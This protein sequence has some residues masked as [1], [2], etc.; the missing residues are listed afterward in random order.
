MNRA[1]QERGIGLIIPHPGITSAASNPFPSALIRV[2]QVPILASP[3]F[4]EWFSSTVNKWNLT[5]IN[6]QKKRPLNL[7]LILKIINF[8]RMRKKILTLIWVGMFV[9]A[10][11]AQTSFN[12][13][14]GLSLYGNEG[15]PG[16]MY[17]P[18]WNIAKL[19]DNT[20]L[21]IGTHFGINFEVYSESS[22]SIFVLDLPIMMELNFG[23]GSH[24]KNEKNSGQ[25][26]GLGYGFSEID[27]FGSSEGIV[28]NAG[29]RQKLK[30]ESVGLR[31]SYLY[32]LK[33]NGGNVVSFGLFYTFKQNLLSEI[34]E[35]EEG[36]K[37]PIR[38][39][40]ILETIIGF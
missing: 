10:T 33:S 27:E 1:T 34:K 2:L 36:P 9:F 13:A 21:S 38:K 32:N 6:V 24:S 4:T 3:M 22:N 35:T 11:S 8:G 39:R 28:I 20:T 25:F 12:H 7:R 18:R 26:I 40:S 23:H 14:I 30:G 31:L 37:K 17:A 19:N 16:L 29:I 5:C 15:I